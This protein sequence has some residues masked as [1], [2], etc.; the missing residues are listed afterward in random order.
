MFGAN[1]KAITDYYVG[2]FQGANPTV[3]R[4]TGVETGQPAL[5]TSGLRR[6][7][8]GSAS[9]SGLSPN[10]TYDFIVYAYNGQGCTPATV[11]S[12]TPRQSPGDVTGIAVGQRVRS[13]DGLTADFPVT[14]S[15]RAGGGANPTFD[16]QLLNG[17]AVVDS[18]TLSGTS[19][20]L[21]GSGG[22]HYGVPLTVKITRVCEGYPDGSSLCTAQNATQAL[23]VAVDLEI[24]GARFDPASH[25]FTWTSWPTGAYDAVTYSCDGTT[26]LPMPAA[27]ETATCTAPADDP[28]PKLTVTVVSGADTYSQDYP[29]SAMP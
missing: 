10:Q 3:C 22:S 27:G 18:G 29:G 23:G 2:V 4:V 8:G 14:I 1:G 24:G 11:V 7:Q 19:G 6:V 9:F 12:A 21:T 17:T 28:A 13:S 5:S 26:Q 25:V 20:V 15:Y 16:Y